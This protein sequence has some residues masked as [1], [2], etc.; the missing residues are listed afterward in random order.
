MRYKNASSKT[1]KT[2][3]MTIRFDDLE[4]SKLEAKAEEWGTS[5]ADAMR[6]LVRESEVKSASK[7]EK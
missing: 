6:R 7:G 2:R 5:L 3:S 1:K 4:R